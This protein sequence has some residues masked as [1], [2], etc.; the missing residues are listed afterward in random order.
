MN[1]RTMPRWL[2]N[3][4]R[5]IGDPR[6]KLKLTP[7]C[8]VF[9]LNRFWCFW[10]PHDQ[11][12]SLFKLRPDA[13][14]DAVTLRPISKQ[15]LGNLHLTKLL[16]KCW[17]AYEA[18]WSICCRIFFVWISLHILHLQP[19]QSLCRGLSDI[20][21]ACASNQNKKFQTCIYR[22]CHGT[23]RFGV[24][25]E[26]SCWSWASLNNLL[27]EGLHKKFLQAAVF[28]TNCVQGFRFH[29][30]CLVIYSVC[31]HSRSDRLKI[32]FFMPVFILS[33][34]KQIM[35][36]TNSCAS[37]IQ[38]FCPDTCIDLVHQQ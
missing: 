19:T 15:Y 38:G 5:G 35:A 7:C 6:T 20:T 24:Y 8:N 13:E 33:S 12:V 14:H 32:S 23:L 3:L 9:S 28:R 37:T 2:G 22:K 11:I 21:T 30:S 1:P 10:F 16:L 4:I 17:Y 36:Q 31:S 18:T 26:V 34:A 27:F 29:V 25:V